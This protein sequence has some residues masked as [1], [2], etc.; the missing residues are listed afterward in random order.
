[1]GL[2]RQES[3]SGLSFTSPRD[4]SYPGIKPVS[5]ALAGIFFTIEPPEVNWKLLSCAWL[6]VTPW[7]VAGQ[8]LLS[9]EF[10]R[11]EYWSGQW[12]PSPGY[13]LDPGIK[14]SSLVLQTVSLP[15]D[16]LVCL[17]AQLCLTLCNPVDCSPPGSCPWDSPG[18]STGVGC[19]ALLQ[20]IFPAQ[21]LNQ[22]LLHCKQFL[23]HL[24]HQGSP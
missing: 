10:S 9:M 18:K 12:I 5:P 13:L 7:T 19:H 4:L 2:P 15:S 6:F 11:Q 14:P 20:G 21:G 3:W 1:M 16:P 23:Y 17:V 24:S 22:G 8:A